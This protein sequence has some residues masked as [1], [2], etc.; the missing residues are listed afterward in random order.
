MSDENES[1]TWKPSELEQD[2]PT[3]VTLKTAEPAATGE[4][5]FGTWNLW[6]VDVKDQK[7]FDRDTKKELPD[8][9]SGEAVCFPSEKLH[10]NFLKHT[11]GTQE[12]VEVEVTLKA[13]KGKK[14]FYTA[15]ETNVIEGGTTPPSNLLPSQNRFLSDFKTFVE[16][17]AFKGTEEEF[18]NFGKTD[19][20]GLNTETLTKLWGVHR[21]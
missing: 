19:T 17:G 4:S 21:E 3:K 11:G 18:I 16:K 7:V 5:K 14:G 20:Y 6:V 9:Y 15:Y 10:E 2:T 8:K 1:P 12:G 13:K